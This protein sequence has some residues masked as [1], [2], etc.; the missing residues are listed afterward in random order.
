MKQ[1]PDFHCQTTMA[2]GIRS[3]MTK[4]HGWSCDVSQEAVAENAVGI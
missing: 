4:A 2:L 1:T 3:P